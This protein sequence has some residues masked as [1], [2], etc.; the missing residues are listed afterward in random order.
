[1]KSILITL[2]TLLVFSLNGSAQIKRFCKL[3]KEKQAAFI[4]WAFESDSA[5]AIRPNRWEDI[6]LKAIDVDQMKGL[7]AKNRKKLMYIVVFSSGC[8][9]TPSAI[10]YYHQ[11]MMKYRDSLEVIFIASDDYGHSH[12]VK[13]A[14]FKY[15]FFAQSYIVDQKYGCFS[16]DRRK[17]Y[18]LRNEFD[19]QCK[20]DIIGVPYNLILDRQGRIL[21]HGY[22]FAKTI[23]IPDDIVGYFMEQTHPEPYQ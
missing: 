7:V 2:S 1:M 14:L 9:G 3:S 23:P 22:R 10:Q 18:L 20:A 4:P 5:T 12:D 6:K 19:E 15:G 16:D 8:A 11:L 21:Y 17:G 13:K